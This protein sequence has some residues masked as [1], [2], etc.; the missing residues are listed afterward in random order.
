[1]ATIEL[2]KDSFHEA[3]GNNA[4]VFV[5]FWASWCGP[6]KS[7]APV[8]E[9][10]AEKYTDIVFAKVNTEEEQELSMQFQI[11]SIPTLMI[12]RD[13]IMLYNQAGSLPEPALEDI[14][15]KVQELDMEE[16]R[17]QIEEQETS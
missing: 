14:I 5:D 4:I 10:A 17:R 6:C 11:R 16:V 8:Y 3:I 15:A 2:G 12:F 9:K 13:Q 7:F 1:V